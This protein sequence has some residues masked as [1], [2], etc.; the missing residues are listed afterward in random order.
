MGAFTG[1][2]R[3]LIFRRRRCRLGAQGVVPVRAF[4]FIWAEPRRRGQSAAMDFRS[5]ASDQSARFNFVSFRFNASID[6]FDSFFFYFQLETVSLSS[7]LDTGWLG[8]WVYTGFLM[9]FRCPFGWWRSYYLRRFHWFLMGLT[10]F[11]RTWFFFVDVILLFCRVGQVLI[12][13]FLLGFDRFDWVLPC[14]TGFWSVLLSFDGFLPIWLGF[15]RFL[16]GLT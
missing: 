1:F 7:R 2:Y 5:T 3:V 16:L 13:F 10:G 6:S 11:D 14:F 4:F 15:D 9:G 12:G 8:Y